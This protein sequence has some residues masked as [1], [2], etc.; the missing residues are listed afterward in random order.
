[1]KKLREVR[2]RWRQ[3]PPGPWLLATSCSWR[4]ILTEHGNDPVIMPARYSEA[5]P[6][7]TL[8]APPGVLE[9]VVEARV[10]VPE[11][12]DMVE[13]LQSKLTSTITTGGRMLACSERVKDAFEDQRREINDLE[14]KLSHMESIAHYLADCHAATAEY[15]GTLKS[16]SNSRRKRF[17]DIC[18]TTARMLR[19]EYHGKRLPSVDGQTRILDRLDGAVKRLEE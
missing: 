12:I 8:D 2:E 14:R 4:R 1:M 5:D 6:Q 7:P 11:L 15:D 3:L 19:N 16:V 13:D 10:L 18:K 9:A 17:R